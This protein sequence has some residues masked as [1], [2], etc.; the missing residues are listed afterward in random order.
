MS[1]FVGLHEKIMMAQENSG[2]LPR[3]GF[4]CLGCQDF[5][6]LQVLTPIRV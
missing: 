6:V 1:L 2:N 4:R 3:R 5:L